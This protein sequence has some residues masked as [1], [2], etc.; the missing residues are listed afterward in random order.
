MT[1]A[2]APTN[3][4][5]SLAWLRGI[6]QLAGVPVGTKLPTDASGWGSTGYVQARVVGGPAD[7]YLPV[8]RPVVQVDCWAALSL[9]AVADLLAQHIIAA[10]R[11]DPALRR[12]LVLPDGY[13]TAQLLEVYALTEPVQDDSDPVL[14]ARCRLDLQ[15][16]WIAT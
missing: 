1:V 7:K 4:L 9:S 2:L 15:F 10:T 5:V 8:G 16:H 14:Y 12:P 3:K 11:D 13:P 6:P